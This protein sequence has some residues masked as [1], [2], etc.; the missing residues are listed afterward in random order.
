MIDDLDRTLE[1]LL[2]HELPEGILDRVALSFAAP[3]S[4]FPPAAVPLPAINLFLYDVR[5]NRELRSTEW[6]V[7]RRDHEKATRQRPPVRVDCSYLVT[8]WPSDAAPNP[9]Q[10]EHH[11]L[12]EV[13]KVLLRHRVIPE[14][15]LQGSLAHQ[16][17]PLPAI[18][19]QPSELQSWGDFWQAIGS[20]P[21]VALNYKVT[22][23]V[24]MG[25]AVETERPVIDK[26]L[27]F[28]P[29]PE[30]VQA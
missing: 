25:E 23:G 13:M 8:A 21:K 10:D 3:D 26:K 12:G 9:S 15:L 16:E 7:E 20:K 19:I 30:P 18:T 1:E 11:I 14:V 24:P 27:D 5:E 28:G 17:P 29:K 4:E 6:I 22:I 2:K